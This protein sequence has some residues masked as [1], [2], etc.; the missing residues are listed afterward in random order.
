LNSPLQAQND[1]EVQAKQ[2]FLTQQY[3]EALPV[4][5]DLTRLYPDDPELNYYYGA[6]LIETGQ[7]TPE[8]LKALLKSGN[9]EKSQWYL[10]QYYHAHSGWDKALAAYLQFRD[11]AAVKDLRSVPLEEMIGLCQQKL[12][13]FE[14][15]SAESE[16]LEEPVIYAPTS[17]ENSIPATDSLQ[18]TETDSLLPAIT[19]TAVQ[20][21]SPGYADSIINF[22]VNAQIT[23]LKI[24]QFKTARAREAYLESREMKTELDSLLKKSVELREQYDQTNDFEKEELA[25]S[26][27]TIEQETYR[28]NGEIARKEQLAN[29]EEVA[30]WEHADKATISRFREL[31][32]HLKDSIAE[33]QKQQPVEIIV[34]EEAP[35]LLVAATDSLA[36]DSLQTPV[37]EPA[38]NILYKIQ[39]GAY[40]NT[41]P[42]WVQQLFRKLSVLRRI[43]NYTDG[44]GVTVYTVGELKTYKDAQ[45]MLKQIKLEGVNNAVI[46]AYKNSERIPVNE[47]IKMS[48]Q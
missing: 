12:N 8:A 17:P 35:M 10:A 21:N 9:L 2:L 43:D 22:P 23:Y 44:Q 24:D 27:L 42:E 14:E 31:V 47:A 18:Q 46:A 15:A 5:E 11:H 13:P 37:T 26:I 33:S 25:N 36:L 4:F 40:R 20:K 41:P 45:Q 19:D 30:W 7:Y 16:I 38:N 6:S 48:E 32:Q 39:I 29:Q 28:L 34:E 1:P 3:A